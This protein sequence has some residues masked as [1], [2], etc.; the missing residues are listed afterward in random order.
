MTITI[1]AA[2]EARNELE[3]RILLALERFRI[4]TGLTVTHVDLRLVRMERLGLRD[5][6]VIERVTVKVEL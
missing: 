3:G 2:Q 4:E 5:E 1:E 6:Q